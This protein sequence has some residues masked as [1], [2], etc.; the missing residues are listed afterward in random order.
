M[1][2]IKERIH[3]F[4]LKNDIK[5]QKICNVIIVIMLCLILFKENLNKFSIISFTIILCI[6]IHAIN[7]LFRITERFDNFILNY[8]WSKIKKILLKDK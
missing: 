5:I 3:T 2:N 7:R 4:L 1:K 6:K 8:E